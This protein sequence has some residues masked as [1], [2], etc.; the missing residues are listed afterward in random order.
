MTNLQ[1]KPIK[2]SKTIK[3]VSKNIPILIDPLK[4]KC[5]GKGGYSS[6]YAIDSKTAGK[7]ISVPVERITDRSLTSF[8][9]N[10]NPWRELHIHALINKTLPV[11]ARV[12]RMV[13][14]TFDGSSLHIIMDR[15]D[16]DVNS[17]LQSD[18]VNM[19]NELV[20]SVCIQLIQGYNYLW[21]KLGFHH[22]DAGPGNLLFKKVKRNPKEK[23]VVGRNKI[24]FDN[25]GVRI[26][27][28]DFGSALVK[29]FPMNIDEKEYYSQVCTDKGVSINVWE[30][31]AFIADLV[32]EHTKLSNLVYKSVLF[33]RANKD[34]YVVDRVKPG[35]SLNKILSDIETW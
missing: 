24:V 8:T 5:I 29:E 13:S 31:L 20:K 7:L 26:A 28:S 17:L 2:T 23:L 21:S 19:R 4:N 15:Y 9:P 35:W 12:V 6:I 22:G 11:S 14:N 33:Y 25:A 34:I 3:T 27:V 1:T 18:P 16:G 30:H 10:D 32:P